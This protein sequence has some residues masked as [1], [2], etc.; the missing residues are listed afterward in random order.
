[1]KIPGFL[2]NMVVNWIVSGS[3]IKDLFRKN[4][5]KSIVIQWYDPIERIT[6]DGAIGIKIIDQPIGK[7][8]DRELRFIGFILKQ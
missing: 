6:K 4:I 7:D 8:E 2:I 3:K 5:G 1:M